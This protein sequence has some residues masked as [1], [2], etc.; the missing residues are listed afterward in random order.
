V[1]SP[2]LLREYLRALRRVRRRP[3]PPGFKKLEYLRFLGA[4]QCPACEEE[5]DLSGY[6]CQRDPEGEIVERYRCPHC[7]SLFE[8]PLEQVH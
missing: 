2:L 6:L 5:A 4:H 3:G 8:F 7:G 1:S